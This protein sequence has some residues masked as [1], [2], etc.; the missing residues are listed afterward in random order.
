[1]STVKPGESGA[2]DIALPELPDFKVPNSFD[3]VKESA[4]K[5]ACSVGRLFSSI[6]DAAI[7]TSSSDK[8]VIIQLFILKIF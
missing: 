8:S 4:M 2:A 7:N 5:I 1:M 3:D 6:Y